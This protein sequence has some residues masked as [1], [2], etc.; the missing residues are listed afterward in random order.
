MAAKSLRELFDAYW[1]AEP[2]DRA[3]LLREVEENDP[4]LGVRLRQLIDADSD[5]PTGAFGSPAL[6][7]VEPGR[8][9]GDFRI[10]EVLGA[11][12]MGSVFLADQQQ[13]V[14]RKVAL[15]VMPWQS[16]LDPEQRARFTAERQALASLSHPNV[17]SFY[18]AGE[19]ED[20][21]AYF[22]MEHVD[23]PHID[24][25]CQTHCLDI[26]A[27]LDLVLQICAGVAHAHRKGVTHRDLKPAN[28]L[29]TGDPEQP[30]VK[31]I[32]FGIAKA[33]AGLRP[34][35]FETHAGRIIGTLNYMSPEQARGDPAADTR[36]DVYALGA[37]L[38]RLL[39]GRTPH[40]FRAGEG[41]LADILGR[42]ETEDPR[43]PSDLVS[44]HGAASVIGVQ[45]SAALASSLRGDLDWICLRAVERDPSRRYGT[46]DDLSRDLLAYLDDRPVDAR[47]PTL[48]YR[49]S[50]YFARNRI[51]VLALCSILVA[52]LITT[53]WSV[54]QA[55]R[56][57][58]EA[59]TANEVIALMRDAFSAADPSTG[60]ELS[61]ED[62]LDRAAGNL[63]SLPQTNPARARLA[64]ELG[65]VYSNLGVPEKALPLWESALSLYLASGPRDSSEALRSLRG[66]AFALGDLSRFDESEAALREVLAL[67]EA[68]TG[69]ESRDSL[70]ARMNLVA[71][72]QKQMLHD[73]A[74]PLLE[75]AFLTARSLGGTEDRDTLRI[76]ANLSV[77]LKY[78]DLDRAIEMAEY[79]L[80][81]LSK[82]PDPDRIMLLGLEYN[83]VT[84]Y[85]QA[86]RPGEAMER[87]V[88]LHE[89]ATRILG[90]D[91]PMALSIRES[92]GHL[93]SSLGKHDQAVA[94]IAEV[95][96]ARRSQVGRDHLDT[97]RLE[98]NLIEFRFAAGEDPAE[99]ANELDQLLDRMLSLV[100][101]ESRILRGSWSNAVELNVA[102]GR[103]RRARALLDAGVLQPQDLEQLWKKE[104]VASWA[105]GDAG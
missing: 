104:G 9:I 102:A 88:A 14:R 98:S 52:A 94:V 15:K 42:L 19:T 31:I 11:G 32:D 59:A 36:V 96:A 16:G 1:N 54:H 41:S 49:W 48:S 97:L 51:P 91:H 5:A 95:L 65:D 100:E 22:A 10:T 2:D 29:V 73:Q 17:A 74:L 7:A 83:L 79:A 24:D 34:E 67:V 78:S 26:P 20:G 38:Y 6:A 23:G 35:T 86:G 47:P 63:E 60:P 50:K 37:M 90:P 27:R 4:A 76:A 75:E 28:V 43:K 45:D 69:P 105:Q 46:A 53:I 80:A 72:Y 71:F 70:R 25:Y 82:Q 3:A 89:R 57:E 103:F 8:R 13:P 93:H 39:T 18:A 30:V 87:S 66:K 62:V 56:V 68:R 84:M 85:R 21:L 64:M 77:A 12:G 40:E 33:A 101:P 58:A 61:V 44:R 92:Q 55:R 99:L 81:G